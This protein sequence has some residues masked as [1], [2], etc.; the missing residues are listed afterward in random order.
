[1]LRTATALLFFL[2]EACAPPPQEHTDAGEDASAPTPEETV[3]HA[4]PSPLRIAVLGDRTGRPNDDVFRAVLEEIRRLAP[5]AVISVGDLIDG[6]QPDDRISDAEAEWDFVLKTIRRKLGD[7]P[8][9]SAAGNHDVW[10]PASEALFTEHLNPPNFSM[11]FGTTAVIFFDTSRTESETDIPDDAL[12]WLVSA[13][14]EARDAAARVVVTH[15][16]LFAL[17]DGG[18]YGSP[19]HDVLIAGNANLVIC[20]HWHHAMADDRD[21]IQYRMLGTSGAVPNRPEHPESGNLAQ[22]AWLV[23]D[24]GGIRFSIVK[25]GAI[26]PSDAFPYAMNQLE[27]KIQ[28]RAVNATGFDINPKRPQTAGRLDITITNVAELPLESKLV[29]DDRDWHVMPGKF[30]VD[31]APGATRRFRPMFARKSDA[32]LFPGP[33]FTMAF[34]FFKETYRLQSHL[35]PT[36]SVQIKRTKTPW[37]LDGIFSEEERSASTSIG[38][39]MERRGDA[40]PSAD[41]QVMVHSDLL[42]IAAIVDAPDANCDAIINND[43]LEDRDHLTVLVDGNTDTPEYARFV[44][45]CSGRI[46]QRRVQNKIQRYPADVQ[47]SVKR[48]AGGWTAEIVVPLDELEPALARRTVGFNIT[49]AMVRPDAY[50]KIYWQPLLEHDNE[51]LGRLSF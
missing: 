21:G 43:Y 31:L 8:L 5:D 48:A 30:E 3:S 27:W 10:S 49:A 14:Y 40:P 41:V 11:R 20:G 34:P 29:F 46:S 12:D 22:F 51:A 28:R 37:T 42:Y 50:G 25:S 47:A 33:S 38:P 16:P 35:T 36:L 32:P 13:L 45:D 23:A 6:Y 7:V 9:F 26:V 24:T 2:T 17:P 15:K 19:L 18:K 44:I 1:M 4:P 39:F